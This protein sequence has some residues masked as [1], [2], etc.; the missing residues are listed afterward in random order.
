MVHGVSSS[1]ARRELITIDMTE[2][3][4]I[5]PAL[6]QV[7]SA[8]LWPVFLMLS[9]PF[10]H[11]HHRTPIP[12][13]HQEWWAAMLGLLAALCLLLRRYRQHLA[14]PYI[15][16]L[17]AALTGLIL[18]QLALLP[19][20]RSETSLL[21]ALYL[22]WAILLM[23][24]TLVLR[25]VH[26]AETLARSVTLGIALGALGSTVIVALQW[27]GVNLEPW[28]STAPSA[29]L[30]GNL[31]QPNHLAL[32]LWLGI[33]ALLHLNASGQARLA[34][35]GGSIILLAMASLLTGSRALWLYAG[36]LPLLVFLLQRRTALPPTTFKLAI[37]ALLFVGAGKLLSPHAPFI[38][39]E[40][41]APDA[42]ILPRSDDV[43]GGLWWLGAKLGLESPW[44]GIGWGEFSSASFARIEHFLPLAPEALRLVPGEHAHNITLHLLAELGFP[45]ALVLIIL[46]FAWA[47]RVWRNSISPDA[48]LGIMLLVLLLLHA[49]LEYTLWYSYFLAIAAIALALSDPRS[50]PLPH[51]RAAPLALVL[52]G[53]ILLI[54]VLRTDY[55]RLERAM[56]WRE[57]N[58]GP[59]QNWELVVQELM[60]LRRHSHYGRYIDLAM[61]GA[62]SIDR[63][64]LPEKTRLC[65]HG[66]AFSPA[67]YVVFKCAALL[68][69][70][71][72][73][74]EA[75]QLFA[76]GLAAYPE[77][78]PAIAG[79]LAV[80]LRDYPELAPLATTASNA[81]LR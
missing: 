33:A 75:S 1:R 21:A 37:L 29:R 67:D 13:F 62:M 76:K 7:P 41:L 3:R 35:A 56:H 47:S 28:I 6:R 54:M 45:G 73:A 40:H 48:A 8:A 11:P 30:F 55:N 59:R 61:I 50:L 32:Q 71:G 17:P 77:K 81:S 10:L 79:E 31:N 66:V 53:A 12:S 58:N 80:L 52:A 20:S 42:W 65:A 64:S 46:G 24:L 14:L 26:G 43:R 70:E 18:L 5:L 19:N 9:L 16:L 74:T 63:Q 38:F 34:V 60:D 57:T 72:R 44:F 39:G 27:G 4:R 36:A 49:Q 68:A 69:L 23:A 78:S 2:V 15:A 22:L 25:A 51:F